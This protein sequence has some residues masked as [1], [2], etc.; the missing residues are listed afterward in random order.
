MQSR[1][2]T[3]KHI[4][5]ESWQT[6]APHF[7]GSWWPAWEKWLSSF[8][9]AGAKLPTMGNPKKGYKAL[10]AAPGTYVLQK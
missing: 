7:D 9:A 8:S 1:K 10:C 4:P 3:D 6:K 5:P 2:K